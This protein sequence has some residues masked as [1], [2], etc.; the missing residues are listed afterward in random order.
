[1]DLILPLLALALLVWMSWRL[2]QAKRYNRFIDWL[3]TDIKPQ[4]LSHVQQEL[5]EQR[6]Q[7]YPNNDCHIEASCHYYGQYPVRVLEAALQRD[8]ITSDWIQQRQNKRHLQHLLF[9]QAAYRI[10]PAP[11]AKDQSPQEQHQQD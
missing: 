4:L 9:I 6:C 5:V 8:I 1:M 3:M 7:Q 2:V 11:V 10:T